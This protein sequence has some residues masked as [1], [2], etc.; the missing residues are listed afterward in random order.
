M[1]KS[2]WDSG[3]GKREV[4]RNNAVGQ[5]L[6]PVPKT[7]GLGSIPVLGHFLSSTKPLVNPWSFENR[8]EACPTGTNA[9]SRSTFTAWVRFESLVPS[10]TAPNPRDKF[11]GL[12]GLGADK[13]L[14]RIITSS[15]LPQE[16]RAPRSAPSKPAPSGHGPWLS[17]RHPSTLWPSVPSAP[18][19]P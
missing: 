15:P 6:Q 13:G 2:R 7:D 10:P 11:R 14:N 9:A 8:L 1:T 17:R 5:C 4:N 12:A 18:A 16:S 19:R 3:N